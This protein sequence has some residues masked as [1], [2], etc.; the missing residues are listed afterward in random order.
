MNTVLKR[1]LNVPAL[2]IVDEAGRIII[3]QQRQ[4][5]RHLVQDGRGT[6]VIF[7]V[8]TTGEWNRL[9]NPERLRGMEVT[10]DEVRQINQRLGTTV[11]AWVG[12]NGNTKEEIL[13]NL[14]AAIQLG[15]DA[16][17]IAPTAIDD[18]H[19]DE[20]TR[21]FQREINDLVELQSREIPVFLYDNADIA[22][23]GNVPHIPTQ[24]VKQLSRLPWIRG[25]KVSASMRELGNYMKAA[26]H[27][28]L[29]GEFGVY[30]GNAMLI[31]DLYRPKDGM[32]G[33]LQEGWHEYLLNY[34]PP[35]GVI[36]GPGNVLPREWQK[37]WRVCW[38]GDEEM[39]DRYRSL[40]GRVDEMVVFEENGRPVSKMLAGLKY[41]LELDGVITSSHVVAGTPALTSEQKAVFQ[42]RY[43]E[44]KESIHHS[45]SELWQTRR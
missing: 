3:D 33:R 24:V 10:I 35:I 31:F 17:V 39:I 1:G 26:L 15:A 40:C 29:P 43:T 2:S 37:A 19:V 30:I 6:D 4:L 32:V 14:D 27:Y 41:A 28:K 44:L 38:A 7:G 21:F 5:L 22:S 13:A 11:E 25:I 36:S 45:T 20:M 42:Q 12:V 16:A 18:L 34:S 9:R 8:G 23:P